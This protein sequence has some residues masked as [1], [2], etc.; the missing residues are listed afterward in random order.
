[1]ERGEARNLA[2]KNAMADNCTHLCFV[3][4]DMKF[5][6]NL[7]QNCI[8]TMNRRDVSALVIPEKPFSHHNNYMTKV[9]VFERRLINEIGHKI[10]KNSI[11]GARFWRTDEYIRSGGLNKDQIAF[12][13]TQP[14]IRIIEK[15]GTVERA[16]GTYLWHDEGRVTLKALIK[17]KYYYFRH[18]P[19]TFNSEEGGYMKALKRWY[20][21]RPYLYSKRNFSLYMRNPLKFVGLL[22]MYTC[23]TL[24]AI[25][26][27]NK[28]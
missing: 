11:E 24:V 1:R 14:T 5:H 27:N 19:K 6:S 23:L 10:E 26:A 2:L 20:F 13:D 17:K 3:D 18:M 15:G 7:L 22:T 16:L 12:E 8:D 4:S 21:F 25:Y 9:K 28:S